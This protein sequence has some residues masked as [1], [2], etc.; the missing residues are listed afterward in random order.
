MVLFSRFKTFISG[1]QY[2]DEAYRNLLQKVL[3]YFECKYFRVFQTK[4]VIEVG[5]RQVWNTN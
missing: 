3:I 5:T 1:L 2:A 4:V